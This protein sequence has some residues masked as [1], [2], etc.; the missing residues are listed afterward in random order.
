LYGKDIK[1]YKDPERLIEK[2]FFKLHY[3]YGS[4]VIIQN[5]GSYTSRKGEYN[6]KKILGALQ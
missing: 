3:P 1:W 2:N 6:I 5:D 4:Y